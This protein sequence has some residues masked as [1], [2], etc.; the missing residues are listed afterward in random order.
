ME[1]ARIHVAFRA[2]GLD[3]ISHR[4]RQREKMRRCSRGKRE[5]GGAAKDTEKGRQREGERKPEGVVSEKS[6]EEFQEGGSGQLCTMPWRLSNARP[7]LAED[8]VCQCE[9]V[10]NPQSSLRG[11]VGEDKAWVAWAPAEAEQVGDGL[12]GVWGSGRASGRV[13]H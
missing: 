10:G 11:V 2:L 12:M 8:W 9:V 4:E 6:R 5:G 1:A 7:E 13:V 3:E